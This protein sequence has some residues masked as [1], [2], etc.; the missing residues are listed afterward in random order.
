MDSDS[1]HVRGLNPNPVVAVVRDDEAC[2]TRLDDQAARSQQG[3]HRAP[4]VVTAAVS[5]PRFFCII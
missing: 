2:A 3:M 5:M 1:V 4:H